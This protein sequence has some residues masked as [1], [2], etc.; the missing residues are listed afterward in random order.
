MMAPAVILSLAVTGI[1][2]AISKKRNTK[3]GCLVGP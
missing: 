1:G 3:G 2:K